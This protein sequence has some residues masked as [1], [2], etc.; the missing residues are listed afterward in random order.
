MIFSL[1]KI[2]SIQEKL[3]L[4]MFTSATTFLKNLA[5]NVHVMHWM[6]KY[7]YIVIWV[8]IWLTGRLLIN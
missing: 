3:K 4:S 1:D 7:F 6:L 2:C 5:L 8:R